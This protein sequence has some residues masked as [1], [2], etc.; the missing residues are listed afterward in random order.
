MKWWAKI[1]SLVIVFLMFYMIYQGFRFV[2]LYGDT[3]ETRLKLASL[4]SYMPNIFSFGN[5]TFTLLSIG[6]TIV[7]WGWFFSPFFY[8]GWVKNS[9][10][11]S[12][13]LYTKIISVIYIIWILGGS[14]FNGVGLLNNLMFIPI[15]LAIFTPLYYFAWRRK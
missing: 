1:T 8:Y 3:Q 7:F 5:L 13:K 10:N 11:E 9:N 12:W 15:V 6:F 2:G 4:G 14:I